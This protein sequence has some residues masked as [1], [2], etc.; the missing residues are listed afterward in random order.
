MGSGPASSTTNSLACCRTLGES[1]HSGACDLLCWLAVLSSFLQC[2]ALMR[3]ASIEEEKLL[4]LIWQERGILPAGWALP[5][6][7]RLLCKKPAGISSQPLPP[8]Q[9]PPACAE[10]QLE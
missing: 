3:V 9:Q 8:P 10:T 5:L 4:A 2:R 1:R 6:L 7:S